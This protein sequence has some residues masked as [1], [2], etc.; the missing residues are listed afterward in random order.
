MGISVLSYI[1]V[2]VESIILICYNSYDRPQQT[3]LSGFVRRSAGLSAIRIRDKSVAKS[4]ERFHKTQNPFET[5]D[6][7][8]RNK[9]M[10]VPDETKEVCSCGSAAMRRLWRM[11]ADLS[12][13]RDFRH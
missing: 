3:R 4:R 9:L 7:Q 11:C 6:V 8:F 1:S 12:K 13:G 2:K 10:E 5:A